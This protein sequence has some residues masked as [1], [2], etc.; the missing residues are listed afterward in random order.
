MFTSMLLIELPLNFNAVPF[1]SGLQAEF[2]R[3]SCYTG[4][5]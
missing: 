3:P 1:Y 2:P 5:R 4:G